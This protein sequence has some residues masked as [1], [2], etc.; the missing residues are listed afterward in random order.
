M[1]DF[2]VIPELLYVIPTEKHSAGDIR[3][4]LEAHPE[5]K[6]VSLAAV[7]L[8][9]NDTDEK[10]PNV[11]LEHYAMLVGVV[12]GML[13]LLVQVILYIKVE[14]CLFGV[15]AVPDAAELGI[16]YQ[17]RFVVLEET[18]VGG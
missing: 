18:L 6:F 13:E 1:T 12:G 10:I 14:S 9:G 2:H 11:A 15:L 17:P 7:D 3:S 4:I 5:I 8:M 16:G